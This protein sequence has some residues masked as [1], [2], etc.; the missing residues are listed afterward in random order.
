MIH[1][2][3]EPTVRLQETLAKAQERIRQYQ[4]VH[5]NYYEHSEGRTLPTFCYPLGCIMKQYGQE[6]RK[7]LDFGIQREISEFKQQPT[8]DAL[9]MCFQVSSSGVTLWGQV[10][11][12][13]KGAQSSHLPYQPQSIL[14]GM[15]TLST[16]HKVF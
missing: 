3:K 7:F 9:S 5:T 14:A 4:I 6:R 10:S 11:S 13:V 1:A 15:E 8:L 12:S 16:L 2:L